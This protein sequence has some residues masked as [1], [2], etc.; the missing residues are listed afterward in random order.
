MRIMLLPQGI[1]D[2]CA[3]ALSWDTVAAEALPQSG[4][5][6]SAVRIAICQDGRGPYARMVE[7]ASCLPEAGYFRKLYSAYL[8]R[9]VDL[10]FQEFSFHSMDTESQRAMLENTDI[11]YFCGFGGSIEDKLV[12]L[13][14]VHGGGAGRTQIIDLIRAM[15][16]SDQML[17][18]G[19]CGG[20]KI[21]GRRYDWGIP[22]RVRFFDFLGGV[23]LCFDAGQAA[24]TLTHKTHG[25]TIQLSSGC[26]IA[27]MV[28]LG[29]F[30][31]VS[32]FPVVKNKGQW[33]PF[34]T[35][36]S[37]QLEV[38]FSERQRLHERLIERPFEPP[39]M[40]PSLAEQAAVHGVASGSSPASTPGDPKGVSAL[41]SS[42]LAASALASSAAATASAPGD[43]RA[44]GCS[45]ASVASA[46]T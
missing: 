9:A 23:S 43:P 27:C 39:G 38:V 26:G 2:Q 37:R 18:V 24:K 17:Y 6:G 46:R 16:R 41:A 28:G 14:D 22:D 44:V 33:W 36:S 31:R 8:G 15:V 1:E 7:D 21:F 34:A 5:G 35:E 12:A 3:K 40:E 29:G 10:Q 25:D 30:R 4:R 42:A 32:S 19:I 11:F 20:A 45:A 13:F